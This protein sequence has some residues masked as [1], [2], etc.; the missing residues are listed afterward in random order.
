MRRPPTSRHQDLGL[1][2]DEQIEEVS[3]AAQAGQVGVNVFSAYGA[4]IG[5]LAAQ[6]ILLRA[7]ER[8]RIWRIRDSRGSRIVIQGG[9]WVG[10][11]PS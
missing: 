6:A 5:I 11:Q 1:T 2:V 7:L 4:G 10:G 3:R 8:D 9:G